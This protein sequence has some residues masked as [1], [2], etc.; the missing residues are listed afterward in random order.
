[1]ILLFIRLALFQKSS[2]QDTF[3]DLKHEEKSFF[4]KGVLNLFFYFP[5]Q[6]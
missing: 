3:S 6:N 5:E 1:M 4:S 2:F